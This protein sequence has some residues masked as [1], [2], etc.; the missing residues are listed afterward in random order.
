MN[1]GTRRILVGKIPDELVSDFQFSIITTM[2]AFSAKK[3]H[4]IF[5]HVLKKR[6]RQIGK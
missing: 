5:N 6:V 4:G 2:S 3:R 1:N